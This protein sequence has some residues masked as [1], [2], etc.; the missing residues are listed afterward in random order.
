MLKGNKGEWSEVYALFKLLADGKLY[1]GDK[2]INKIADLFFPI[3]KIIK[4]EDGIDYEYLLDGD[5]VLVN[6]QSEQFQIS[7]EDFKLYAQKLFEIIINSNSTFGSPEVEHFMLT[8]NSRKLKAKSSIKSDIRIVIHDGRINRMANLGFSI[9]SELGGSSTLLNAG[10]TTNF[11]FEVKGYKFTLQEIDEVNS[12]ASKSKIRDRLSSMIKKGARIC[13]SDT[14]KLLFKNNLIL[15]DSL[16]PNILG[17]LVFAYFVTQYS[18]I[19][20]LT[21]EIQRTNPLKYD[22]QFQHSFYEY[23]IKKFLVEVALGMMPSKVWIGKYDTTGGHLIVKQNGDVLCYHIYDR[24]H[25]EDYL[26][27]NT[28][29][30]TASSS[31]HRFGTLY[32]DGGK[33]YMK[34]NLQVRF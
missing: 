18:N 10:D 22:L 14:N 21:S 15:I 25:F 7:I 5:I 28:R 26:F 8:F 23:K 33:Y 27:E 16:L 1:P 34:L 19:K 30:E 17:E 31:R 11:I 32:E 6:D 4:N 29:L 9:K 24:N 12:I 20:D 13:Y 3:I 2:T